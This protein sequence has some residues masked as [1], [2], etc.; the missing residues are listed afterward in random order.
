MWWRSPRCILTP[1]LAALVGACADDPVAPRSPVRTPVAEAPVL[2]HK[3][4]SDGQGRVWRP[5][6][7]TLNISWQQAA[8]RC[9]QN[10]VDPCWGTVGA[11]DLSGWIWA[12]QAQV[13]DLMAVASP[14]ILTTNPLTGTASNP[15]VTSFFNYFGALD[16]GGCSGYVCSFAFVMSGWTSTSYGG[17]ATQWSAQANFGGG[18]FFGYNNDP[19]LSTSSPLRGLL[20]WRVDVSD[21]SGV[22]ANDDAGSVAHP[23]PGVAVGNV[24]DNDLL[25]SAPATLATVSISQVSSTSSGVTLDPATGAVNVAYGARIGTASLVYRACEIARPSNCDLATVTVTITGNAVDAVDDAGN[26]KT[27]GGIAIANVLANDTFAGGLAT[28][29]NVALREVAPDSY[30]SITASGAVRVAMG[31]PVGMHDIVYEICEQGVPTNCDQA[32]ARVT[33]TAYA[34]DAVNDAGSVQSALGGVA[35]ANVLANDKF[36]GGPATLSQVTLT[37][38]SSTSGTVSLDVADGSVDVAPGTTGGPHSLVYR[39]CESASPANCDQATAV[40][41]IIPLSYVISTPKIRIQEGKSGTFTVKLSQPITANVTVNLSYLAGTMSVT[42]SPASLTFTPANWN[43]A[44]TV[45]FYTKRDSDKVDNAGTILLNAPGIANA[46]VVIS[47]V[48]GDRKA[49]LPVPILQAPMNG[50]TVSGSISVWGTATSTGGTI[51]EAKFSIDGNRFATVTGA[52]GTYRAPAFST[53]GLTNGWH[54]LEMRV[55][56]STT[57]DGRTTIKIFVQN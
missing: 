11:V 7:Q 30:L 26:A 8:A 27:G 12:T 38:V 9:P 23:G 6:T 32:T 54:E 39:I 4:V 34:I 57:N 49:T 28:L 15:G 53:L 40:V 25:G 1:L 17:S 14:A 19:G 21:G 24:L 44:Q 56:D 50:E 3:N 46:H 31:T 41:T 20:L 22:V 2:V 5:A 18:T 37:M 42:F 47:G 45:T 35:V 55:T 36:D 43:V 51:V 10:G 16:I 29:Q 52:S 33:V 13:L 48:D